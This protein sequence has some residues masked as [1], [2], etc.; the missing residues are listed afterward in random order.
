MHTLRAY[1]GTDTDLTVYVRNAAGERDL[2]TFDSLSVLFYPYGSSTDVGL[3]VTATGNSSG[4]ASF[5][6][7]SANMDAYLAQDVYRF[8]LKGVDGSDTETLFT[9]LLEAV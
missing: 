5:T 3:T 2:T 6:I 4:A 9:G 7:T 1:L 8:V